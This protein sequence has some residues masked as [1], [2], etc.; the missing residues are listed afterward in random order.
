MADHLVLNGLFDQRDEARTVKVV[1]TMDGSARTLSVPF[2][3]R[4]GVLHP[5][6]KHLIVVGQVTGDFQWKFF[7]VPL[8]GSPS[9]LLGEIP[10]GTGDFVSLSPDGTQLAYTADGVYTTT[11]LEI[12]FAP[13]LQTIMRR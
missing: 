11:I 3:A 7:N 4:N 2:N 1:S 13:A 8:D 5:N 10:R 9:R 12:D 6:G